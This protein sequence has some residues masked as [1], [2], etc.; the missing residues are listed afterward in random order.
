M[1]NAD[2]YEIFILPIIF[3][4]IS[5]HHRANY[6]IK[7]KAEGG[8]KECSG[9]IRP[10][11]ASKSKRVDDRTGNIS[12]VTAAVNSDGSYATRN[13]K[14]IKKGSPFSTTNKASSL[15]PV[16]GFSLPLRENTPFPSSSNCTAWTSMKLKMECP[17]PYPNL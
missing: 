4:T 1:L 15:P 7:I 5:F 17:N 14:F 16:S 3:K 13:V 11:F 6:I 9:T 8:A 12:G 10:S 2:L